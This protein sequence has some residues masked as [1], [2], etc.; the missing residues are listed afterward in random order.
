MN[1]IAFPNIFNSSSTNVVEGYEATKQN[2]MLL[3]SCE[4]GEL[5]GDPY[6]GIR[7]KKYLYDQNDIV[8]RDILID[9]I[10]TQIS[11][12]MP[13]LIITRDDI[14]VV[15]DESQ[16]K[17]TLVLNVKAVN[18]LDYTTDMYNIVL[19]QEE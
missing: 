4:K 2:L 5:F 19:F 13:Q 18:K 16:P 7:L 15:E 10:Y 9:E 6:Y 17:G 3:L 14:Q 11:L 1:S 12:F 8:L